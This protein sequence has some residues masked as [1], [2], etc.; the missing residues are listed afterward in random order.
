VALV[1]VL[2]GLHARRGCSAALHGGEGAR[3]EVPLLDSGLAGS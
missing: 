1:D 3:I 2:T